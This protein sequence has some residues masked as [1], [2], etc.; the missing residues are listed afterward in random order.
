MAMHLAH[1]IRYPEFISGQQLSVAKQKR[2]LVKGHWPGSY[3]VLSW[4][5][6]PSH[7]FNAC[8][9][10]YHA[11]LAIYSVNITYM[12][13]KLSNRLYILVRKFDFRLQKGR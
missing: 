1:I 8:Y 3:N 7:H 6:V 9:N 11:L 2:M 12:K 13:L 10:L 5:P 4:Q